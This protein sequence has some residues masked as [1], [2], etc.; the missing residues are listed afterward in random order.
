MRPTTVVQEYLVGEIITNW[1]KGSNETS[2]YRAELWTP[3]IRV[4]PHAEYPSGSACIC[5]TVMK[6][7]AQALRV[8]Y[9]EDFSITYNHPAGSNRFEPSLPTQDFSQTYRSFK[10]IADVCAQSRVDGGMHFPEAIVAGDAMCGGDLVYEKGVAF[11]K[12]IW[13]GNDAFLEPWGGINSFGHVASKNCQYSPNAASK[14]G[15]SRRRAEKRKKGGK[16]V[17]SKFVCD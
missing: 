7:S 17:P 14:K 12:F 15:K 6:W 8:D 2:T 16:S 5:T 1:M 13:T 11:Q 3:Y 10:D 4:M 9:D